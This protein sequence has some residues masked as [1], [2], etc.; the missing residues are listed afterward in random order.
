M[1]KRSQKQRIAY[2]FNP[3]EGDGTSEEL[4][5][6]VLIGDPDYEE[7]KKDALPQ[8]LEEGYTVAKVRGTGDGNWVF[9]LDCP[10]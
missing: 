4:E 3:N 6:Y 8:L 7:Y 2:T 1:T 9:V 5:S 10:K